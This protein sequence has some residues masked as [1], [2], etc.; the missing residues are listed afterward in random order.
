M[1]PDAA[2]LIKNWYRPS[3]LLGPSS[4]ADRWVTMKLDFE[5]EDQAAFMVLGFGPRIEVLAPV[6][7]QQRIERDIALMFSRRRQ[8]VGA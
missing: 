7:L 2:E 3:T 5:D 1:D 4:P 6:T 8:A